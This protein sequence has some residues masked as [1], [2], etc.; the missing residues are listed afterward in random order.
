MTLSLI[1]HR[2]KMRNF[3]IVISFVYVTCSANALICLY[4]GYC[5]SSTDCVAGSVCIK[6]SWNYNQCME[7]QSCKVVSRYGQPC[8]G[9]Q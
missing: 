5:G 7:D 8:K 9:Q 6:Q 4:G 3:A 1:Y 2:Q